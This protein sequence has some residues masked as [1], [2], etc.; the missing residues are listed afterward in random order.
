MT[1]SGGKSPATLYRPW[2]FMPFNANVEV[3]C[4]CSILVTKIAQLEEINNQCKNPN[5]I[6]N[7]LR[8]NFW[9]T[10]RNIYREIEPILRI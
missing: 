6:F 2:A 3:A 1:G 5:N 7:S 9:Q 4:L 10:R 8:L